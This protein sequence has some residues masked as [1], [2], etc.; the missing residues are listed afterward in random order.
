MFRC[1]EARRELKQRHLAGSCECMKLDLGD[2]SSVRTFAR[3]VA[4]L[5][6]EQQKKLKILVNNAG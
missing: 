2:F 3:G 1:E 4:K 6:Q 5:L